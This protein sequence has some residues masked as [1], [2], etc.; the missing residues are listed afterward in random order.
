LAVPNDRVAHSKNGVLHPKEYECHFRRRLSK[1]ITQ[2][3]LARTDTW[4]IRD[5]GYYLPEAIDDAKEALVREG[6]PWFDRFHNEKEV[7][8]TLI[9]D[10]EDVTWGF[11]AKDAPMRHYLTGY[12]ALALGEKKVATVHLQRALDSGCF[13]SSEGALLNTL[14]NLRNDLPY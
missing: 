11:G 12:V 13:K 6:L 2:V 7:F 9:E 3:E 5:D 8:R 4:L 14:R 10:D 1:S